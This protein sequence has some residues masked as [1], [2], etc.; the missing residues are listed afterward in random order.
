MAPQDLLWILVATLGGRL[1][2]QGLSQRAPEGAL[3]A[4][5]VLF[6]AGAAL[7]RR[8]LEDVDATLATP[9]L[10]MVSLGTALL[11]LFTQ[12]TFRPGN[13]VARAGVVVCV[14]VLGVGLDHQLNRSGLGSGHVHH[15]LVYALARAATL[16]WAAVESI[17][18]RRMYLRRAALGLVDPVVANRLWLFSVWTSALAVMPLLTY[19]STSLVTSDGLAWRSAALVP[20]RVLG[21]LVLVAIFLTFAP[22]RRYLRWVEKRGGGAVASGAP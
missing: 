6:G 5:L 2:W 20:A 4:A 1:L 9:A 10:V 11:A 3:G 22:P 7:M 18:F 8:A 13:P 21:A 17:H 14:M 16:G 12:W 19:A 15:S